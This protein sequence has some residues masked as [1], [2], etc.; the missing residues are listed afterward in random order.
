M[1]SVLSV[2]LLA[3]GIFSSRL[4]AF[5]LTFA[6]FEPF[7]KTYDYIIELKAPSYRLVNIISQCMILLAILVFSFEA[8]RIITMT[9]QVPDIAG[10]HVKVE[11]PRQKVIIYTFFAV[12]LIAFLA[13][14]IIRSKKNYGPNYRTGLAIAAIGFWFIPGGRIIFCI[15]IVAALLEKPVKTSPEVAFDKDEIV[16]NSFP[17]KVYLWSDV[18]NV[19]LKDGLLTIDFKNNKLIQ[20]PVSEDVT[21]A[22]EQDFNEFCIKMLTSE[23]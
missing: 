13:Y 2:K 6:A 16:F 21:I 3:L 20:K 4:S 22:D 9:Y 19:V 7:M 11:I 17:K 8:A 23:Q 5:W 18:N 15:Y 14:C 1:Q 12:I 10:I